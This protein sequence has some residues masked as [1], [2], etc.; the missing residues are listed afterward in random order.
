[1][2]IVAEDVVTTDELDEATASAFT[3][4]AEIAVVRTVALPPTVDV[5][6]TSV[7]V[8][9]VLCAAPLLAVT[10]K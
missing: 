7:V 4:V 2:R 8:H 10:V 5:S 9:P 3:T 6:V 1:V